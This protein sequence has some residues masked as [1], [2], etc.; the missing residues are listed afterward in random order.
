MQDKSREW[1][2]FHLILLLALFGVAGTLVNYSPLVAGLVLIGITLYW[3]SVRRHI[4]RLGP[5]KSSK[6]GD[7]SQ[8]SPTPLFSRTLNIKSPPEKVWP[9]VLRVLDSSPI[10]L[11]WFEKLMGAPTP[12]WSKKEDSAPN[13]T[14]GQVD[15]L[16]R[17]LHFQGWELHCYP[18]DH[19][20]TRL[21]L[22]THQRS[23]AQANLVLNYLLWNLVHEFQLIL[24]SPP[25][26]PNNE[27]K[28]LS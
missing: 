27:F 10:S 7:G 22:R 6:W 2:Y 11:N 23:S 28:S 14:L 5:F 8:P 15:D 3:I 17:C 12:Q 9:S 19:E 18:G 26:S 13:M 24:P 1:F 4:N 16:G 20:S 21:V 25:Q